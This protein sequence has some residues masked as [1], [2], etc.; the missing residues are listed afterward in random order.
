MTWMGGEET[1][2][3]AVIGVLSFASRFPHHYMYSLP[4]LPSPALNTSPHLLCHFYMHTHCTHTYSHTYSHTHRYFALPCLESLLE[5]PNGSF[6]D[7]YAQ[8]SNALEDYIA[9][10]PFQVRVVWFGLAGCVCVCWLMN[11]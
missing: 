4:P 5:A 7:V 1:D 2:C 8:Q 3:L 9:A 11:A 10:Q 6:A